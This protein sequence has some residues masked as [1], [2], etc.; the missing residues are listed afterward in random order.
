MH[1]INTAIERGP[2]GWKVEFICHDGDAVSVQVAD[3]HAADEDAALEQAK[4]L[5]IQ[6]TAFG[7]RGGGR[8]LNSYD[9]ASNGN[10]DSDQPLIDVLH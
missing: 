5:M 10:L 2:K 1:P 7:T 8:S 6:L 3:D 4:A 9:A